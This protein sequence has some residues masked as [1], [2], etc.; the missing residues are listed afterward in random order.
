VTSLDTLWRTQVPAID[1]VLRSVVIY[2]VLIAGMR[3]FGKREVGQFTLFDL[4][5]VLLVGNAVQP[6][7]TGP[8]TSLAGGLVII[9][10]LFIVNRIV[11]ILTV[12]SHLLRDIIEGRPTVIARGGRWLRRALAQEGLTPDDCVSALRDH[13]VAHVEDVD[14][15]VLEVDGTLSVVPKGEGLRRG[16]RILGGRV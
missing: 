13:G 10:T 14:L 15:A 2:V 9:A 7:I 6:A 1:L 3:L 5:L 12:S 16:N 11:N 8:D 4:A